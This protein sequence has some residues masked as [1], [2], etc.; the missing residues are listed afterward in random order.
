MTHA[1]DADNGTVTAHIQVTH[2]L[3]K[4]I[5]R[6]SLH[7]YFEQVQNSKY[8][9]KYH[10]KRACDV[11]KLVHAGRANAGERRRPLLERDACLPGRLRCRLPVAVVWP[12]PA[13]RR[14][15]ADSAGCPTDQMFSLP[16]HC[17]RRRAAARIVLLRALQG[18]LWG[19]EAKAQ[20]SFKEMYYFASQ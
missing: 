11:V 19:V 3:T 10:H 1:L 15:L 20:F 16:G 18:L 12:N 8:R 14:N 17:R 7:L 5:S 9:P 2:T 13:V 6:Q 4:L